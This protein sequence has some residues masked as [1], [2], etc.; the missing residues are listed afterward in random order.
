LT[1][2]L[3]PNPDND[4]D[5]LKS[6]IETILMNDIGLPRDALQAQALFSEGFLDSLEVVKLLTIFATRFAARIQPE[7][8]TGLRFDSTSAMAQLVLE[9]GGSVARR[10]RPVEHLKPRDAPRPP[11]RRK[12]KSR[13]L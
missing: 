1:N 13:R 11:E 8:V 6:A 10:R 5:A 7:Q 3:I 2:D 9:S 12:R 4:H